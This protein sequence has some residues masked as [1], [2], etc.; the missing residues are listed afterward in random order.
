MASSMACVLILRQEETKNCRMP[1]VTCG[2]NPPVGTGLFSISSGSR[3]LVAGGDLNAV[4]L[5]EEFGSLLIFELLGG[6][7][8]AANRPAPAI[9]Y[10][11]AHLPVNPPS[12]GPAKRLRGGFR[13]W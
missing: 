5:L 1:E 4:H 7:G 8:H 13:S 6:P 11:T 10:K 3:L 12:P 2:S 9:A